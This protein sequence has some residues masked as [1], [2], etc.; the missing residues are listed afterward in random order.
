MQVQQQPPGTYT[1]RE[2][3]NNVGLA[4]AFPVIFSVLYFL[5]FAIMGW[6]DKT[7]SRKIKRLQDTKRSMIKE[8]KVVLPAAVNHLE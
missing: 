1:Y 5:A 6:L 8:L 4:L 3:F 7:D 2:H